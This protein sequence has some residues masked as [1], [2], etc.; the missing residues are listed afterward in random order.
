M[1]RLKFAPV[2]V[3]FLGLVLL[4]PAPAMAW[5][6]TQ[7][8]KSI[9]ENGKVGLDWTFI[10]RDDRSIKVIVKDE[11]GGKAEPART[12]PAGSAAS[13]T[14]A[15]AK[16]TVQSGELSFLIKWAD[17]E[18]GSE[19][20]KQSYS[21]KSCETNPVKEAGGKP[22]VEPASR[23]LPNTGPFDTFGPFAAFLVAS[24]SS[25]LITRKELINSAKR[26]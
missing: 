6:T 20:K 12:V 2:F 3:L 4:A 15:T 21:K 18:K 13:G 22:D 16:T 11:Q 14:I 17:G 1:L 10:N 9:C 23:P 25:W 19:T 7:S 24:A 5:R 26:R 8:A